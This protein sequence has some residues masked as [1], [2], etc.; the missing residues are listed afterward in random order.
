VRRHTAR[1]GQHLPALH[2]FTLDAAQQDAR[3]VPATTSSSSLWNI[4]VPV[5]TDDLVSRSPTIST[6]S[7]FL[8]CRG[9]LAP[10][11]PSRVP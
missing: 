8:A 11:P 6:G 10:S 1:L 5:I 9:P 3:I 2:I 4:S 7:P